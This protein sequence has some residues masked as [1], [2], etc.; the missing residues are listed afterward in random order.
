VTTNASPA[1]TFTAT[2]TYLP[3]TI[4]TVIETIVKLRQRVARR[5]ND[6][7]LL[8]KGFGN[9]F[10]QPD[11]FRVLFDM[12][13][14]FIGQPDGS[15]FVV[16]ED[17]HKAASIALG[18]E[19]A[20]SIAS[21]IV[22]LRSLRVPSLHSAGATLVVAQCADPQSALTMKNLEAHEFYVLLAGRDPAAISAVPVRRPPR[23]HA[24]GL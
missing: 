10:P 19:R 1:R 16:G 22:R 2:Q 7:L 20:Q 11:H 9:T 8:A 21:P 6:S 14:P 23:D 5:L 12:I 24:A 3:P 4:C 15:T 13:P 17:H 18:R